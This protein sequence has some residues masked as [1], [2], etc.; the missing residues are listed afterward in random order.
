MEPATPHRRREIS[1]G[2]EQPRLGRL[3]GPLGRFATS[4]GW[5]E[6]TLA[7]VAWAGASSGLSAKRRRCPQWP[8]L[9][10]ETFISPEEREVI[11]AYDF[12]GRRA[13][14]AMGSRIAAPGLS[15]SG[16]SS[17]LFT[18]QG[19]RNTGP[20]HDPRIEYLYRVKNLG[21]SG[22]FRLVGGGL[23]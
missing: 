4:H 13:R 22:S 12:E 19:V 18:G 10:S 3:L 21:G 8:F 16:G 14:L 9:R 17:F 2:R 11:Y 1:C 7:A 23:T 15:I 5:W 6:T 20:T